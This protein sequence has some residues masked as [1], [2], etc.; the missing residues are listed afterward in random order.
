[1]K[2]GLPSRKHDMKRNSTGDKQ[3]EKNEVGTDARPLQRSMDPAFLGNG[4]FHLMKFPDN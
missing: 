4:L 3:A 2:S 1:M